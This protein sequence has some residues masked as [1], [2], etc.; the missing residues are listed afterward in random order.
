MKKIEILNSFREKLCELYADQV[1]YHNFLFLDTTKNILKDLR[2]KE[3]ADSVKFSYAEQEER[4]RSVYK[5]DNTISIL[6]RAGH[7]F[8]MTE[9][10]L[11]IGYNEQY[12]GTD[13][14]NTEVDILSQNE[15]VLY[16][17][18]KWNKISWE[19][20]R[21][22]RYF[23][24][25]YF[26]FILYSDYKEISVKGSLPFW[27]NENN[28]L[29]LHRVL[30]EILNTYKED[31]IEDRYYRVK[32]EITRS[33]RKKKYI[34]VIDLM[35]ADLKEAMDLEEVMYL[36]EENKQILSLFDYSYPYFYHRI[37]VLV[38]SDKEDEALIEYRNFKALETYIEEDEIHQKEIY[39]FYQ[40]KLDTLIGEMT[41]SYYETS[42]AYDR[43]KELEDKNF[44][45]EIVRT[46]QKRN[47]N[48]DLYVTHFKELPLQDRNI[49]TISNTDKLFKSDHITLLNIGQLPAINFPMSHPKVNQT[50]IAH[51]YKTD[52]YL[53]IENY[54]YELLNDRLNEFFYIL[55]CLG[56]TSITF[57]TIEEENKEEKNHSNLKAE[58]EAK[59]KIIGGKVGVDYDNLMNSSLRNYLKMERT[60]TFDPEKRPYIPKD[61]VWFPNEFSWQR[62]AQQRLNGN[63][64]THNEVLS[65]S[66]TQTLSSSEIVDVNAELKMLFTSVKAG[67]HYQEEKEIKQN[68]DFSC[69]IS[70]EFKPMKEF[71]E[72]TE[73]IDIKAEE[74]IQTPVQLPAPNDNEARYLEEIHFMLEDDGVIDERERTIL[75]RFRERYNITPERAK[76]LE[77]QAIAG[78]E[79]TSEEQEYLSEY[80]NSLQ[81]GAISEKER[82]L[83]NRLA[84]ALGISEERVK[85]LEGN[86]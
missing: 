1:K 43:L 12:K 13:W 10:E 15:K 71:P 61:V 81:D 49:I 25:K 36:I 30:L 8:F 20:I 29:L 70:V 38:A 60:Q 16:K 77:A 79:L 44:P 52:S 31:S 65:S 85:E 66:Q 74:V 54:D 26:E 41:H 22:I 84:M 48:Y 9:D 18:V 56:A 23:P 55:Q 24:N 35:D 64:L 73:I 37:K 59:A 27:E 69:R 78:Q 34:D 6:M 63:F 33:I 19:F 28:N 75:E 17:N 40:L 53:P 2:G 62:L 47:K 14:Y 7:H 57:E 45:Y 68:R 21:N 51:P 76:E 42:L 39:K 46:E 5:I 58:T 86:L 72:E 67:V 50:Y 11:Y 83:L 3:R 82:R 4:Y 32:S 80:K